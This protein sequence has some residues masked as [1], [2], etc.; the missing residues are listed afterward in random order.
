MQLYVLNALWSVCVRDVSS[1]VPTW[2]VDRAWGWFVVG[3]RGRVEVCLCKVRDH[4]IVIATLFCLIFWATG[5]HMSMSVGMWRRAR[6]NMH[7]T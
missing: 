4:F 3:G 7:L 2:C 1:S 6:G 5:D